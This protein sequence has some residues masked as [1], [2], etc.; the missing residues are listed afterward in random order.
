MKTVTFNIME[1]HEL[2]QLVN[3]NYPMLEGNYNCIAD[4]EWSNG[5][6][7]S[8]EGV[9]GSKNEELEE[10]ADFNW[11]TNGILHDLVK[12]EILPAGNYSIEVFY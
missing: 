10:P 1:Y 3:D 12:R 8:F 4:N 9:D 2:D 11:N 7:H 6:S 5:E